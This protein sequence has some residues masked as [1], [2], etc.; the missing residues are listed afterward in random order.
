MVVKNCGSVNPQ[1]I[2]NWRIHEK[3]DFSA[4]IIAYNDQLF[5]NWFR[6]QSTIV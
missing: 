4:G 3:V 1:E 2:P 5:P 6:D